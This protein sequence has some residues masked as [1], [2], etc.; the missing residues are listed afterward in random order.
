MR[1]ADDRDP[2]PI[3]TC[4]R[5][6]K[7]QHDKSDL[8]GGPQVFVREFICDECLSL[9]M[10]KLESPMPAFSQSLNQSLT[11]A[12][13][14]AEARRHEYATPEHLLLA[15]IDDPD[16]APV[17]QACNVDL[18][19]LRVAVW[20]SIS[21]PDGQPL[22]EG[23][24]PG[25]SH[26]FREDV[27]RA[28]VHAKSIGR[29]EINGAD[30]LVAVLAGPAGRLLHEQ[31]MTRYDAT[32]FISHGIAKDAPALPWRAGEILDH[33]EPQA[34][35]SDSAGSS[36]F[37]V[38]LLNDDYTPMEFVVYVLEEM[39]EL[40]HEV[41]VRTMLQTHHEGVGECGTFLREE[42]EAKAAQVMNLARQ[43]QHPL[44]CGLERAGPI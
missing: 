11:R 25:T 42:A 15:L 24:V 19:K 33:S 27:Q 3:L 8:A 22:P 20:A 21:I 43:Y 30:V 44:R 41:A 35:S 36:L 28:A 37:K 12:V 18:E 31:G 38:Q 29:E 16:A 40:E 10:A 39:F 2:K 1:N 32:I 9:E 5:C 4:S 13:G 7:S 6:G 23:T 14:L 26:S 34:L 17:L